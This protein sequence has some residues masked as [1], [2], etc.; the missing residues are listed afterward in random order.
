MPD[1]RPRLSSAKC[2][3]Y[4]Q[5]WWKLGAELTGRIHKAELAELLGKRDR[6]SLQ[7][8]LCVGSVTEAL[9][10]CNCMQRVSQRCVTSVLGGSLIAQYYSV[11]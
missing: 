6:Q 8:E 4:G 9:R 7:A 3:T 10:L 5:S 2:H 11:R 1:T